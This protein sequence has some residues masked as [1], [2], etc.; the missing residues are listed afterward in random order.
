MPEIRGKDNPPHALDVMDALRARPVPFA[1]LVKNSVNRHTSTSGLVR[2]LIT[3]FY[4]AAKSA[5]VSVRT[6]IP[7]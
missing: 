7:G 5:C 3:W 6:G 2:F 4:I 1:D